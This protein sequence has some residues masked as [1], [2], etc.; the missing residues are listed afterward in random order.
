VNREFTTYPRNGTIRSIFALVVIAPLT[1]RN[2][3]SLFDHDGSKSS[4]RVLRV[5]L[6]DDEPEYAT[7][8]PYIEQEQ[9]MD[10]CLYKEIRCKE[11][12]R[13]CLNGGLL[14]NNRHSSFCC[15]VS[16]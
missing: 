7:G 4:C 9:V 14:L 13:D 6:G 16:P 3:D 2:L 11:L 8:T 10:V 12:P 5:M 1:D 15:L